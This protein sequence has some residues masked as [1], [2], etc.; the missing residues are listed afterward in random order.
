MST[1]ALTQRTVGRFQVLLNALF[2]RGRFLGRNRGWEQIPLLEKPKY[3]RLLYENGVPNE[4]LLHIEERYEWQPSD[5][6]PRLYAGWVAAFLERS[7]SFGGDPAPRE[8]D[9]LAGRILLLRFLEVAIQCGLSMPA[10]LPEVR[11]LAEDVI[12]SLQLDGFAYLNGKIL[13]AKLT[14]APTPLNIKSARELGYRGRPDS[15]Q[16]AFAFKEKRFLLTKNGKDFLETANPRFT[17]RT[18]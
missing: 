17:G 10:H 2:F 6:L 13:D 9:A 5:F 14:A 18:E 16:A 1:V 4:V 8:E 3:Q 12:A 11:Q 7:D 15:F